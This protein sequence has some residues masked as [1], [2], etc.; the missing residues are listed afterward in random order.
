MRG[1]YK[2]FSKVPSGSVVLFPSMQFR[3]A[4][5]KLQLHSRPS[6]SCW[7]HR[8]KCSTISLCGNEVFLWGERQ[9]KNIARCGR[10][11]P[12][13]WGHTVGFVNRS[14]MCQEEFLQRWLLRWFLRTGDK[15]WG[16][17]GKNRGGH[18]KQSWSREGRQGRETSSTRLRTACLG[19]KRDAPKAL[20]LLDPHY[21]RIS[22]CLSEG[23]CLIPSHTTFNV[24]VGSKI[25]RGELVM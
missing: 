4:L 14:G 15:W 1:M 17:Y 22:F 19:Q 11:K 21:S 24:C 3:S 8:G 10:S 5:R 2:I 9:M 12:E 6:V 20:W 16:E 23:N 25:G 7:D 13:S 18:A